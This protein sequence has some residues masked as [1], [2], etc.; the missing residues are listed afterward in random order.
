MGVT[1]FGPAAAIESVTGIPTDVNMFL[2]IGVCTIYTSI[3][4]HN[5]YRCTYMCFKANA[6]RLADRLLLSM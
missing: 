6:V 2:I 3:V 1:T 4:R 5:N